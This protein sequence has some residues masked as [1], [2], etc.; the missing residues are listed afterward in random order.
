METSSVLDL[1]NLHLLMV[2]RDRLLILLNHGGHF[3]ECFLLKI[4]FCMVNIHS[5][6]FKSCMD[7]KEFVFDLTCESTKYIMYYLGL[8]RTQRHKTSE[9]KGY[10]SIDAS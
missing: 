1:R 2:K 10:F 5:F 9:K 8:V 4:S 3:C 6:F 7:L